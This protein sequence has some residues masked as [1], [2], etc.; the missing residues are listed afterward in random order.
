[1]KLL[2]LVILIISILVV[3]WMLFSLDRW[4]DPWKAM[5]SYMDNWMMWVVVGVIVFA[6]GGIIKWTLQAEVKL[7]K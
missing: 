1:M 2:N 5:F 3:A 7:L 6:V 4:A